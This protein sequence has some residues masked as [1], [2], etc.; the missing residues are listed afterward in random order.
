M[1]P[2]ISFALLDNR[3]QILCIKAFDD[4]RV[5]PIA[6]CENCRVKDPT[7]QHNWKITPHAELP[8][9]AVEL[10]FTGLIAQAY[11][12]LQNIAVWRSLLSE[13]RHL[14]KGE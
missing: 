5:L 11:L 12:A 1:L 4:G 9:S 2:S 7:N 14:T 3:D 8:N 10:I 6:I 13:P